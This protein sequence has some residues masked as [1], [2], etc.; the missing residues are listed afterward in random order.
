MRINLD[1]ISSRIKEEIRN[2]T[3]NLAVDEVGT[4]VELG[5]YFLFTATRSAIA[6]KSRSVKASLAVKSLGN[7]A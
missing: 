1:E 3:K 2:Y 4:V 7:S 6:A 5:E